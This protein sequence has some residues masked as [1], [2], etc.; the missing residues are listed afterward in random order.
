MDAQPLDPNLGLNDLEKQPPQHEPLPG[1]GTMLWEDRMKQ[2]H[3]TL[4]ELL[5]N[6]KKRLP[7]LESLMLIGEN[8]WGFLE[9]GIYRFYHQSF[10]VYRVQE[11]TELAVRLFKVVMPEHQLNPW[12]LEIVAEGTGKKFDTS[13]NERWTKETRPIV[14]A[15]FHAHYFLKNMVKYGKL[16][17]EPP[18]PMPSGWAS[19]LYLYNLR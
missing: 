16:L 9:D 15:A 19:V 12:L 5:V 6:I 18:N 11:W 13:V 10:K 2:R 7:E 8:H 14:E 17:E 1:V 4:G 3:A